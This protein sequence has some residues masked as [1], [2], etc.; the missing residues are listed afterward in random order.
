MSGL[1]KSTS[2]LPITGSGSANWSNPGLADST[3]TDALL[4]LPGTRWLQQRL[5][6]KEF[7][8]RVWH[9]APGLLPFCLWL[10]PHPSPWGPLLVAW[11][12]FLFLMMTMCSLLAFR[13]IAR[14]HERSGHECVFGYGGAIVLS[15]LLFRGREEIGLMALAILAF[16]DGCATLGGLTFRGPKLPWNPNKSWSGTACFLVMGTLMGGLAFWGESYPGIPLATAFAIAGLTTLVTAL[17]E[18]LRSTWNDNLR[19]SVT[20]TL[21]GLALSLCWLP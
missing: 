21:M 3:L 10:I 12:L 4:K 5:G 2:D 1:P 20:A 14:N 13:Q 18:S 8:R 9:I 11:T 15:L 7:R 6:A 17:I 16:G 19:V